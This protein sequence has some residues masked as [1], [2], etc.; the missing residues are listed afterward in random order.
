MRGEYQNNIDDLP[1]LNEYRFENLFKVYN[2]DGYYFYNIIG[3]LNIPE[4][5]DPEFYYE[6]RVNKP[7]PWT[8]ISYEHYET[9]YLWWLI[10]SANQIQNPIEFA[11][12]GTILKIIKPPYVREVV[13]RIFSRINEG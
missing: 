3:T 5:L 4:D 10:C 9:I 7:M 12:T 11:K 8:I 6:W 2:V 13:D 1:K